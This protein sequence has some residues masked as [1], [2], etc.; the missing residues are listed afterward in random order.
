MSGCGGWEYEEWKVY[1]SKFIRQSRQE[2]LEEIERE[3]PKRDCGEDN[4]EQ[5][6]KGFNDCL[7]QVKSILEGKK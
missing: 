7:S 1:F 4:G 6:S 5:K 2:L 3:L